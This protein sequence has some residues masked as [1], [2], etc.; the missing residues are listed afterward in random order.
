MLMFAADLRQI[1]DDR[2]PQ[3]HPLDHGKLDSI[4]SGEASLVL[5]NRLVIDGGNHVVSREGY[6]HL[7]FVKLQLSHPSNRKHCLQGLQM[8]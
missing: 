2:G 1:R 5:R 4:V 6:R 7:E 3:K 8:C